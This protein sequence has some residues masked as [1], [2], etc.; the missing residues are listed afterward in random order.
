MAI[1]AHLRKYVQWLWDEGSNAIVPQ[2]GTSDGSTK[3]Y[4]LARNLKV[5]AAGTYN[6]TEVLGF[7]CTAPGSGDWTIDPIGGSSVGSIDPATFTAGQIYPIHAESIT[8]GT[9]GEAVLFIP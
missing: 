7:I 4:G 9:A 1:T 5:Q 3:V 8:V 2:A 6:T